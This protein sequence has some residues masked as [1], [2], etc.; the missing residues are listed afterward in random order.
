MNVLV[1]GGSFNPPHLA[2]TLAVVAAM[3][4]APFEK[5]LVIPTYAHAFAK[6]LAPFEDRLAMCRLAFADF[7]D[8]EISRIEEVLGGESRTLKTLSRLQSD[9]P[10]WRMRLLVGADILLER[11]KW[12]AFD[13]VVKIAPLLV[14]G[15]VGIDHPEAPPPVLPDVS[16]TAL[17]ATLA[18]EASLS[19]TVQDTVFF[20]NFMHHAVRGY[21]ES[22]NLYVA[23]AAG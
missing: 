5:V 1:F 16:S 10:H 12:H 19:K 2:H 15:R 11:H 22:R 23:A 6:T 3:A 21:I 8:V 20:A 9:N 18:A 7:R 13:E 17:R 14:L 4:Q